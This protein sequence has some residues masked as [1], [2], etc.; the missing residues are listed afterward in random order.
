MK[1]YILSAALIGL[2]W[3]C[4]ASRS[5]GSVAEVP[6]EVTLDLTAVSEDRVPVT[7]DP[8]AFK[9]GPVRFYI[10]KTVP[11]TY[12]EDNYGRYV[13]SL[14]AIDYKG[15]L[16]EVQRL[17][18]NTWMFPQGAELDRIEYW[19]NDSYD[20]EGGLQEAPFSPAGSNILAGKHFML[21]LHGF[22][23]YFQGYKEIAYKLKMRAPT[24]LKPATSLKGM[25]MEDGTYNFT[26]SRYFD[27][28]DNP[29]QWVAADPVSF[30]VED[31]V[32]NI[33]VYSPNG[34][35]TAADLKPFMEK[36]MQA[37][38]AFLGPIDGTREYNI[39][40]YLSTL[41]EDDAMGFGALE[42]HTSTVVVLPEQMPPQQLEETMIDVVS[43]EF[44]H[45]VTPLNI[46]SEEIQYFDY[47]QP[48]M[49]RHLWM[50]EGTTEYFA[51]LFQIQQGLI[52]EADFYGR[53]VGKI[54]NAGRYNDS[55]S[56]TEM[57]VNVLEEPYASEYTNVYE[58]GALINMALD[59]RLRELSG[60]TYGVLNLMKELAAKYD[61]DTPFKD[62]ALIEEIV[63]LTYPEIREF[64]AAHVEGET[65]IDYA[66]YLARVGLSL[67]E[68][69]ASS[70]FF[71]KDLQSQ[72]PYIDVDPADT[73]RIFIREGISL[74]SFLSD[75]GAQGGDL[76]K[77]INGTEVNLEA[78]RMIIGQSFGWTPETE[79][80]MVV[81]RDGTLVTLQGKAGTPTVQ[82]TVISE[83]PNATE[84][85]KALRKAW[86]KG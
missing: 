24:N 13:D 63:A 53:I 68:R 55:L 2:L 11:G 49:S 41:G 52:E 45:I 40:L 54:Q 42:H 9:E 46:H 16:L 29:V 61:V 44:F 67:S 28:V 82:E 77:S 32:V 14:T 73:D 79:V 59:I 48:V 75:L 74:N 30:Q 38:K 57:S 22:V 37:Q 86:L 6:I 81:E 64:F 69:G 12:S 47:N 51:N 43:H 10:P 66:A 25:A 21:N 23:G 26:A 31:I 33:S 85:Q 76:I 4:G 34:T 15:K 83:A 72:I 65:P 39:L 8:G 1:K 7:V 80:S 20:S 19:V 70:S 78:I 36:M 50:Y 62:E 58:K 27:V 18:D 5:L 60:G 71:I 35:Y 84:T 3:S 17:D 56:F